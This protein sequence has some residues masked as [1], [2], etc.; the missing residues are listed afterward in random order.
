MSLIELM[1]GV[2]LGLVTVLVMSQVFLAAEGN[3]R[4]TAS[5]SD[6]QVNGTLA[7][8]AIQ[9]DAQM[10]G[11]GLTARPA[12]LGCTVKA[13]YGSGASPGATTLTLV[14]ALISFGSGAT[15][16]T[17]TLWQ[18]NKVTYAV[19][20]KVTADHT[21]TGGAFQVTTSYGAT[22]G[23]LFVAVPATWSSTAWCSMLA[24]AAD[25]STTFTTTQVPHLASL[26]GW[27]ATSSA[28]LPT[29]G[30]ASGSHLVNLGTGLPRT[31]AVNANKA[32]Q[33][34]DLLASNGTTSTMTIAPQIVQ[35]K[36]LYG[37]DTDLNGTI[38]VFDATTPTTNAG[39]L[40]VVALRVAVV[41][42]SAQYE[43]VN[44]VASTITS[45]NG[46]EWVVDGI[47]TGAV[48]CSFSSTQKCI[49]INV[50]GAGTGW[51]SYRYKVFDTIIP[52]RNMLWTR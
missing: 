44:G 23:D 39:W 27:N 21:Q 12:A 46:V 20:M 50:S 42:Q 37:K 8:Y 18:S 17:L 5:G 1:I 32:L 30:Y 43:A 49:R 29:A 3:K 14:P 33:A 25:S 36:A 4:T 9:R 38:D 26:G 10:A 13:Q 40:Q 52:L 51:Q 28:M 47:T 11:Y 31:Y 19:P 6:A 41:A 7:L 45:A 2:A 35:L 24:I 22:A 34:T 16:D 15:P 48:A